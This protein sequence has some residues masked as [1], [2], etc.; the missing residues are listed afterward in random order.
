MKA[1]P[2]GHVVRFSTLVK[3][4]EPELRWCLPIGKAMIVAKMRT[5]FITTKTVCSLP[6]I[7]ARVDAMRAWQATVQRKTAYMMPFVGVQLPSRAITMTDKN[8][9]EKP[10]VQTNRLATRTLRELGERYSQ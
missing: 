5:K 7:L 10:S 1:Q 8:I 6:M 9:S 4:N 2:A 3:M